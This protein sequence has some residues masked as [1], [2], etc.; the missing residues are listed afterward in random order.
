M[1]VTVKT[2]S[3]PVLGTPQP[4]FNAEEKGLSVRPRAYDLMPDGRHIV[5]VKKLEKDT[6]RNQIVVVTNWFSEFEKTQ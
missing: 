1:S 2:D 4:L 5:A 6:G 3:A